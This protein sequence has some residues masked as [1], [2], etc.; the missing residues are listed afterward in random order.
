MKTEH[1][2]I[3]CRSGGQRSVSPGILWLIRAPFA[4]VGL[5][6]AVTPSQ[7]QQLNPVK[8]VPLAQREKQR[9]AAEKQRKASKQRA[10]GGG[11][12]PKPAHGSEKRANGSG[13][14]KATTRQRQGGLQPR[15]PGGISSR[16]RRCQGMRVGGRGPGETSFRRRGLTAD[17]RLPPIRGQN[18]VEDSFQVISRKPVTRPSNNLPKLL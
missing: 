8:Y 11:R 16:A 3:G 18:P 10:K 14:A 2:R 12:Q 15:K 7:G 5:A 9:K 1:A 4:I 6:F 13:A 17:P